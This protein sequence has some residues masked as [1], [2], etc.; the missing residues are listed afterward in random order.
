MALDSTSSIESLGAIKQIVKQ[1]GK[2]TASM[3][4]S[5][6][7]DISQK[8]LE[9]IGGRPEYI[10]GEKFDLIKGIFAEH[11]K[12]ENLST[13]Y[14]LLCLDA[15]KKFNT[16]YDQLFKEVAKADGETEL[17]FTGLGIALLNN[18]R[19]ATS[20]VGIKIHQNT[21]PYIKRNIVY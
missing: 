14:T 16:N 7:I 5:G 20:Q 3:G 6:N 15:L 8:V 1:F 11:T 10:S 12:N 4:G 17:R 13:A 19:P 18:Y 2:I 21:H 9:N